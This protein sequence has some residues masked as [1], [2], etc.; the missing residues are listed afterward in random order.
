MHLRARE[1]RRQYR[2]EKLLWK[3]PVSFGLEELVSQLLWACDRARA[4]VLWAQ[5]PPGGASWKLLLDLD[6]A[7]N[8]TVTLIP[9]V[10]DPRSV[11]LRRPPTVSCVDG[12][13]QVGHVFRTAG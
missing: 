6:A 12:I 13:V 1:R 11:S 3:L 7:V 9:E 4:S 8:I 2:Y 5:M 10:E